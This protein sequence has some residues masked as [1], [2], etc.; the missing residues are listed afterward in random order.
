MAARARCLGASGQQGRAARGSW[1]AAFTGAELPQQAGG[2]PVGDAEPGA[3]RVA[4][5]RLAVLVL[6]LGGA[7]G[8]REQGLV[9]LVL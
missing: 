9:L 4:G 2:G 5:D 3:Q 8:R 1:R 6:V 7:A